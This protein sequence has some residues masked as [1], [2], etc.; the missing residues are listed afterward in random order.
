[1]IA[2][3]AAK[4]SALALLLA[5][6]VLA[7]HAAHAAPPVDTRFT[8]QGRL[9]ED[10]VLA[11][12]TYDIL[13]SVYSV[14]SGGGAL[15]IYSA[16]DVTVTNGLFQT[17]VNFPQSVYSG[18]K[19]FMQ[20]EVRPGASVGAYSILGARQELLAVP[21]AT[22]TLIP[23]TLQN[24]YDAGRAISTNLGPVSLAA[25][26]TF[27]LTPGNA[28]A[29]HITNGQLRLGV[30]SPGQRGQILFNNATSASN[31]TF[32]AGGV[33]SAAAGEGLVGY[34]TTGSSSSNFLG[35]NELFYL[36]PSNA[37]SQGGAL[38]LGG[39]VNQPSAIRLDG[40]NGAPTVTLV[41]SSASVLLDPD[42][43]TPD[44]KVQLPASSVWSN[45]LGD[46]PG[47][48]SAGEGVNLVTLTGGIDQLLT[49]TITAPAAGFVLVIATCQAQ[50]GH[51]N[52]TNS[53]ADFGVSTLG[54]S[55]PANQD[56]NLSLSANAATGTYNFPVTV[57]GLFSVPGGPITMQFLARK[58]S[59][60]AGSQVVFD[61]QLTCV[62]FPTSYGTVVPTLL[63]GP[64]D[65]KNFRRAPITGMEVADEQQ[66]SIRDNMARVER[67]NAEMR[68]RLDAIEAE[69]RNQPRPSAN[70]DAK[71]PAN[72][73]ASQEGAR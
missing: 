2:S 38:H 59:G 62:Y 55:F 9:S 26:L 63:G 37:A 42:N 64:P 13:F 27:S 66:Q 4:R 5:A 34:N 16:N 18:A 44:N 19:L 20:V 50:L 21:F 53:N 72:Q 65:S 12:G 25:P 73:T 58:N 32:Y 14:A 30:Q 15:A 60:G 39:T 61:T 35:T 28:D 57:H 54:G 24:A 49:R 41:G 23:D 17:E 6:G 43:A 70:L 52:G 22:K 10:G 36:G 68:K 31:Y 40:R 8:Y 46:E 69:L 3:H 7:G 29:I 48:A 33:V 67:E 51:T 45:E 71:Q 1:M 47:V 11:N 56:V